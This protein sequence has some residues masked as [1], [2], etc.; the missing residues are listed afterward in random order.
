MTTT[1]SVNVVCSYSRMRIVELRAEDGCVHGTAA[2]FGQHNAHRSL[3]LRLLNI[4]TLKR[5][6]L[7]VTPHPHALFL[8]GRTHRQF[9]LGAMD[10]RD[11]HGDKRKR[12]DEGAVAGS[13]RAPKRSRWGAA[14]PAD[15]TADAPSKKGTEAKRSKHSKHKSKH[16]NKHKSSKH[17]KHKSKHKSRHKDDK[18]KKKK[19][20]SKK[21]RD[22]N[23]MKEDA[24]KALMEG[25]SS[26]SSSDDDEPAG[27]DTAKLEDWQIS[28]ADYFAKS[29]EFRV[30]LKLVRRKMFEDLTSKEAHKLFATKFVPAWNKRKLD[31]MYY[32]CVHV[33]ACAV[34]CVSMLCVCARTA[35]LALVVTV[36]RSC[37]LCVCPFAFAAPPYSSQWHPRRSLGLCETHGAQV[38][39]A[40]GLA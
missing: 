25:G 29:T 34:C 7:L 30:F 33:C 32:E 36:V 28:S 1:T 14:L 13:E 15:N 8:C 17:S 18:K 38:V 10:R 2:R 26:S 23:S 35:T 9:N 16:S 40:P 39:H 31:K 5:L 12:R 19:K 20:S 37:G 6:N 27:S 21:E 22:R 11:E 24:L 4:S 3:K